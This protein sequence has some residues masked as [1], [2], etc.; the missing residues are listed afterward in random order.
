MVGVAVIRKE[1]QARENKQYNQMLK[2]IRNSLARECAKHSSNPNVD[3]VVCR[4]L[5][6]RKA[7][8]RGKSLWRQLAT[9]KISLW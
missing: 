6:G 4:G 5:V 7:P 1:R 3:L 8:N 2:E 9:D